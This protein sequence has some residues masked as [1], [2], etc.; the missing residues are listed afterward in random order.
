[1]KIIDILRQRQKGPSFEFFPARTPEGEKTLAETVRALASYGPMYVSMTCGAGGSKQEK[2]REAVSAL[3]RE[4]NLVVMPHVTSIEVT[5]GKM[6]ALLDGYKA[7]GIE[8]LMVLRGD[9]PQGVSGFDFQQQ[10]F[11]YASDLVSFIRKEYGDSFCI[12][13]AVYPEGHLETTSLEEDT[14]RTLHKIAQGVDF[15][16]TQMFFDNAFFYGMLERFKKNGITI[17]V[18]PGILPLR[19]I[20]VVRKFASL[21]RSTVPR[22]IEEAMLRYEG[23]P[24]EMERVGLEFTI[25]QCRDLVKNGVTK[26]HFYTLNK[27][28]VARVLDAVG[29]SRN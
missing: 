23:N 4:G 26:M 2:T 5:R 10:D 11:A 7:S 20:G 3:L 24:V 13:V 14:K 9:P 25:Q 8:N 28:A 6:K 19:D 18:L 21:C 16:V 29:F 1:M 27:L 17:P 12:G 15:A 22:P